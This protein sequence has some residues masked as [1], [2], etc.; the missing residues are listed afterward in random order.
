MLS[1]HHMV[2]NIFFFVAYSDFFY[3][4]SYLPLDQ[5]CKW[6]QIIYLPISTSP[7]L[8]VVLKREDQRIRR[9]TTVRESTIIIFFYIKM[10]FDWVPWY[11]LYSRNILNESFNFIKL[12]LIKIQTSMSAF[13]LISPLY[14]YFF[15]F[16]YTD[17][18]RSSWCVPWCFHDQYGT[19][20]WAENGYY[21]MWCKYKHGEIEKNYPNGRR[22][23]NL[24]KFL[25]S[26]SASFYKK[27]F[28]IF[29]VNIEGKKTQLLQDFQSFNKIWN[30]F[31]VLIYSFSRSI[32]V[33]HYLQG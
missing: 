12:V 5:L 1:H 15:F 28:F 23:N 4:K 31:F 26:F 18:W 30:R 21:C 27:L 19:I 2:S 32:N 9:A 29:N 16:F 33:Y 24:R 22:E 20:C 7:L 10:N 6:H 8:Y 25:K 3:W 13:S 11:I 14:L 17:D